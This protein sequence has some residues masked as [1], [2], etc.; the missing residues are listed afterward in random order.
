MVG[1]SPRVPIFERR[2]NKQAAK[3]PH[4]SSQTLQIQGLPRLAGPLLIQIKDL[5]HLP[6]TRMAGGIPKL[7]LVRKHSGED[8]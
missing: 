8:L 1:P 4:P 3:L 6:G 7:R 2:R 5:L